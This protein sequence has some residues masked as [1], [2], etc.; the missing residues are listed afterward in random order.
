M[1]LGQAQ[2]QARIGAVAGLL[3]DV[4][5]ALFTPAEADRAVRRP[6]LATAFVI[7]QGLPVGVVR[8][9]Q[10]AEFTGAQEAARDQPA[11]IATLQAHQH[12]HVRVLAA[13][14]LEVLRRRID[15][16]LAQDHV[17]E[18]KGQRRV[19]ALLG[20]ATVLVPL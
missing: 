16:E 8:F 2:A 17:A 13:V 7:G 9:A 5:L 11:I 10:P 20:I 14:V 3:L 12:R 18:R 15:M 1:A 19:G 4:P 6:D